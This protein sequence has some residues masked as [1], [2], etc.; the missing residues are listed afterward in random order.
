MG[1]LL[2]GGLYPILSDN[3]VPPS[4][5]PA[6]A[7]AVAEAGAGVM[8]LRLKE[9]PDRARLDLQR[10][11]MAALAGSWRGALVIDDRADLALVARAE[12]P[13]G[14]RIGLH[15]GQDDLPAAVARELV[16]PDVLLGLSTHDLAQVEAARALPVDYLGFGP[17]FA[18]ST[19]ARH[20]A[21]VG[22]AGLAAACRV[23]PWPVVAIGGIS[24]EAISEVREA[25][26][27][28]VAVAGALF[29][30]PAEGLTARLRAAREAWS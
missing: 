9:L 18:T 11:V 27:H 19:K 20:D 28:G 29:S 15:V 1:E 6:V 4:E 10:A 25:G 2:P 23:A 8:Q 5:L 12:A 3:V 24:L 22:L 14:L 30:G 17:L 21:T 7:R 26:A 13:P 16:G